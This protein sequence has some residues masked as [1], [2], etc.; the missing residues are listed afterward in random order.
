MEIEDKLKLSIK[1][2][3]I[4]EKIE[5]MEEESKRAEDLW[6]QRFGYIGIEI[7]KKAKSEIDA[8]IRE[9]NEP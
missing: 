3:E 8:K 6:K 5:E 1:I 4:E 7:L 9:E 2:K